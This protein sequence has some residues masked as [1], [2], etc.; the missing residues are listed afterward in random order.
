M[1]APL[2]PQEAQRLAA[3]QETG[4][5]DTTGDVL[6]DAVVQ[7]AADL[8][9]TPIAAISLIDADRQYFPAI[10]GLDCRQTPRDLAFCAHS[11]L[12]DEPLVVDDATLDA[13]FSDNSLVTGAPGI[14]FYAGVPLKT[15]DNLPLGSLCVIDTKARH[16]SPRQLDN[17]RTLA[18]FVASHLDLLRRSSQLQAAQSL[19]SM[20]IDN[21][22]DYEM[23]TLNADGYLTSWSRGGQILKGY[24]A[25]E[26]IGHHYREF[27]S[28]ED[29]ADKR[30][31]AILTDAA[32]RGRCECSGWRVRKDGSS[33]QVQGSVSA[34]RHADGRLKGFVKVA[35]DDT[36]SWATRQQLEKSTYELAIAN[37]Q[38]AQQ[39]ADLKA[40]AAELELARQAAD[41]ASKSKSEFLANM[42]HEIRTP[43]TAILGFTELIATDGERDK[44]PRQRLEYIDT[45]RRN[46]EHLLTLINDIL[47]ISKIEA[48]KL[49]VEATQTDPAQIVHE[50]IALMGV[51]AAAKNLK[52]SVAFDTPIPARISSDPVRLRQILVNLV[53]NAIKF[54]E[55]GTVQLKVA[56]DHHSGCLRFDVIDTGIGLTPQQQRGL[57]SPFAQADN[58]TTR[59]FGGTGLGLSISKR[60]AEMLGGDITV[61]STPGAGSTFS[62]L[63]AIGD[64]STSPLI[65]PAI[66]AIDSESRLDIAA[67]PQAQIQRLDGIRILLAEDGPDN[68]RLISFHLRKLGADVRTVE[69]GRLAV[70][71][72]TFDG[73]LDSE[74]MNPP[75]IDLVI[76]DMQMP[77][78]D[79]YSATRLLRA[80]GCTLP[81][82]A[83]TAHA[84]SGDK[85][86]CIEAGCDS[87]A[88]KPIDRAQLASACIDA[89]NLRPLTNKQPATL[90]ASPA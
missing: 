66:S 53:G 59:R 67:P 40:K 28:P 78:M 52:I 27:F 71:A 54:T 42:S 57:F 37:S 69:N 85:Q 10:T 6:H 80:K 19:N 15:S 84:M 18:G 64:C 8:C 31:E 86:K 48:G 3:L 38:M 81:I 50:V 70:E 72:L 47:D 16:I 36:Q 79:G 21:A 34:V 12:N 17:L 88:S 22:T 30:P 68:Q 13:R 51:K 33:F 65:H 23:I 46:G 74:L 61:A 41:D 89:I 49:T 75:M 45:I 55:L 5:L 20:L 60:L 11:I 2:H 63:I 9:G 24:T 7:L 73:R 32:A 4:V 1:R 14:R 39:T 25:E 26:I 90:V 82:V 83:L 35:R 87:Y 29:Q 44:A 62:A 56:L 43:M 58:S 76:T 77:E